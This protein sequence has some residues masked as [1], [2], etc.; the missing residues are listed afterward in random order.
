MPLATL[1][2]RMENHAM[3][4][5]AAL[6]MNLKSTVVL[7]QPANDVAILPLMHTHLHL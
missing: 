6:D 7:S 3:A 1:D 5:F 2:I 4:A